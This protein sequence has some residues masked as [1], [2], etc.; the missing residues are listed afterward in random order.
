MSTILQLL[1]TLGT[2]FDKSAPGEVGS[3]LHVYL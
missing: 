2:K 3:K 1:S